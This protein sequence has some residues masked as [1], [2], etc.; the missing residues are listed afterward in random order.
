MASIQEWGMSHKP[1]SPLLVT[2]TYHWT[3]R[4]KTRR[5]LQLLRFEVFSFSLFFESKVTFRSTYLFFITRAEYTSTQ[6]AP[7]A[8]SRIHQSFHL[9][10]LIVNDCTGEHAVR[11]STVN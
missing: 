2:A 8:V 7:C 5:R 9:L 4:L 3:S 10:T 1:G 6:H 11:H